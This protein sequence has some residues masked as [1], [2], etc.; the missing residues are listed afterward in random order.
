MKTFNV[1]VSDEQY[2]FLEKIVFEDAAS[3]IGG[4][5]GELGNSVQWC[6]DACMR[7]EERFKI[8]ACYISHHCTFNEQTDEL[9]DATKKPQGTKAD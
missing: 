6:I 2:E 8:D 5:K 3:S 9:C 1:S 7:I 4:A